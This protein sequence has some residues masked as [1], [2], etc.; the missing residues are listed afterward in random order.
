M[1]VFFH[2]VLSALLA[3]SCLAAERSAIF[4]FGPEGAEAARE[5][6]SAVAGP[7]RRWL[8]AP[9]SSL[10][11][12]KSGTQ[13]GVRASPKMPARALE[14]L[15]LEAA[16]GARDADPAA[17]LN[18]FEAAA[19]AL[20]G[21]AGERWLVLILET[22]PLSTAAEETLKLIVEQASARSVHIA[23]FDPSGKGLAA[24]WKPLADAQALVAVRSGRALDAALHKPAA[25]AAGAPP[26]SIAAPAELPKDLP[27]HIRF[28]RMSA[29]RSTSWGTQRAF[30]SG[31]G[32]GGGGIV[33]R[34]GGPN[35]EA[36]TGVLR[37]LLIVES[38]L[39]DLRF[40][41][42]ENSRTYL[43]RA[44]V[45]QIVR[46]AKGE[47]VW[48]ARKSIVIKGPSSRIE[49]RMQGSL[50]YMREVQ[51]PAGKY[52]LEGLVEDQIAAKS[53]GVRE[54]L[55]T[56]DGV[57]GFNVSDALFIKPFN[58]AADKFEADQ[59]LSYDGE[60][61]SPVLSPSFKAGKSFD[62]QVYFVIYPDLYGGQ[63]DIT[64]EVLRNGKSIGRMPLPFTDNIRDTSREGIGT[65]KGEQ[66]NQFPYLAV[67]KNARFSGG[68]YEARITVKQGRNV[69]SR[70]VPFHVAGEDGAPA[71]IVSG[72]GAGPAVDAPEDDVVMP[73]LD[74]VAVKTAGVAP[75]PEEQMRYWDEAAANALNYSRSLPNFRC[76]Q[77]TRRLTAPAKNPD[78][79]RE[80]D[81]IVSELVYENGRETYRTLQVNGLKASR[82]S[83]KNQG[84][85]SRGEFGTLLRSLFGPQVEAK[86]QWAGRAM[87]GGSLCRVFDVEVKP[88]KSNFVLYH[89]LRQEVAGYKG[90]VFIDEE[91]G[92]VRRLTI[93]GAGL[94]KDFPLKSPALS[95]DYGL[96]QVSGQD[97]LVPLK[98]V[99]QLRQG[100]TIVRNETT[101]RDYRK[102]EADSK[103]TY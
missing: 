20:E 80:G 23:V 28:V 39:K 102:F 4:L 64:V 12:R 9:G 50:F 5:T 47:A 43:A 48:T 21:Q 46:N 94:P 1:T 14:Q 96:A 45:T 17:F 76:N 90:R 44:M 103:V 75:S 83:K 62:L 31:G 51:L 42:D 19:Q 22:P 97:Y 79:F 58:G 71:E 61:I 74:P 78:Q 101:F 82:E 63:P 66:K 98:S 56:G 18:S 54:A 88:E 33:T 27:V 67:L 87:A 10:E 32:P 68:E 52:T 53:G 38:P 69:I 89:N 3:G 81:V 35:T 26:P 70:T 86:Y 7:A 100:K 36:V 95:L 77:E 41:V 55:R 72:S 93:E 73:E 91:Q 30:S 25:A 49:T 15:L 84:V 6:S 8:S 34:E 29:S 65:M 59:V 2:I 16:R 57:P 92:L 11:V 24:A 37:G 99:L 13:E 85:Y 60:A 40:Q